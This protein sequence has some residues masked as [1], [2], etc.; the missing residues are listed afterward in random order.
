MVSPAGQ[1]SLRLPAHN[2]PQ[3]RA[4]VKKKKILKKILKKKENKKVKVKTKKW[5]SCWPILSQ[6][7]CP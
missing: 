4:K 2:E 7:S 5:V 1:S 6:T 3:M